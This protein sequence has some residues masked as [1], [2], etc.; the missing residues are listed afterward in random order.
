MTL[1]P[2]MSSFLAIALPIQRPAPVTKAVFALECEWQ[3]DCVH[4]L[5][6]GV[7]CSHKFAP[8]FGS[9]FC[10]AA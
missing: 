4:K 1:A 6:F 2:D 7:H 5:T 10:A 9:V 8:D 3:P